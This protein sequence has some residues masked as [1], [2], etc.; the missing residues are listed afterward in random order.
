VDK[1][2]TSATKDADGKESKAVTHEIVGASVESGVAAQ[3]MSA[4]ETLSLSGATNRARAALKAVPDAQFAWSDW[5]SFSSVVAVRGM[6]PVTTMTC[7]KSKCNAKFTT[8][9]QHVKRADDSSAR[10][11][12]P[13]HLSA[14]HLSLLHGNT[15][16]RQRK[17][18]L[19]AEAQWWTLR[20]A[21]RQDH[22]EQSTVP[23]TAAARR[24]QLAAGAARKKR[25]F[26]HARAQAA[27]KRLT[28]AYCVYT[29]GCVV[30]T[31]RM[32]G[33]PMTE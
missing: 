5:A 6:L 20:A 22:N 14:L 2:F 4:S 31:G 26:Q 16:A 25:E 11:R 7:A 24:T 1:L 19:Q 21:A 17:L 32:I 10:G 18:R 8:P 15:A 12:L 3:P 23:G 28:M 33:V 27:H 13:L 9:K 29:M 30:Y